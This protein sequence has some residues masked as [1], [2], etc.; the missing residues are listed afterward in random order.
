MIEPLLP[1][2]GR[3]PKRVDDRRL[4]QHPMWRVTMTRH[5]GWE[6]DGDA[7]VAIFAVERGQYVRDPP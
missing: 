2:G 5:F 7:A 3:G 1:K 4:E 6:R